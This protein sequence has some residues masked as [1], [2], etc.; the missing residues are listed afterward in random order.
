MGSVAELARLP[1]GYRTVIVLHD[2]EGLEHEE[3]AQI[4]R[5]YV[6]TSKSQLHK[7]RM[8][9]RELLHKKV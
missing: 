8:R 2:I 1:V 9:L 6:G 7:A 3:V 4:L 5:C